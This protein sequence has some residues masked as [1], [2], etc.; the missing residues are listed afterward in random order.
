[1][2]GKEL[3]QEMAKSDLEELKGFFD[4]IPTQKLP[5][6]LQLLKGINYERLSLIPEANEI[7]LHLYEK[8]NNA[9]H[10]WPVIND[11]RVAHGSKLPNGRSK[12]LTNMQGGRIGLGLI[13]NA[14]TI[15][16]IPHHNLGRL[17]SSI[18][19]YRIHMDSFLDI[20][21]QL[22]EGWEPDYVLFFLSE[23]L[24]LPDGLEKS[25]YPVIGLPG[26]PWKCN[27]LFWDM[28]FFDAMMPAMKHMCKP[29]ELLGEIKTLYTSCS[30]IQGYVPWLFTNVPEIQGEKEY[31]VVFTG[32][33][34]NPF[35]KKRRQYIWKLLKLADRY[36]IYTGYTNS[37]IECYE[38]MRN[39]KIVIHCP[40]MQGGVNLRP[41]EAIACGALL[42]HEE[43]D[44]SI[45]EFFV[46]DKEVV[47]FN[48]DNFEQIIEYYLNHVRE[49]DQIVKQAVKKNREY[50]NIVLLMMN[51]IEKIRQSKV[52]V[53]SRPADKLPDDMKLNALG[54]SSFYARD[55]DLAILRFSKAILI[56]ENNTKYSNNLAVCLMVQTFIKNQTNPLIES[57]LL[58]ANQ[59]SSRTIVSLFNLISFYQFIKPDQDKFLE[60]ANTLINYITNNVNKLP[61]FS[62]DELF[63]Y[64]ETSGNY[65]LDSQIFRLEMDAL[66]MSFPERN[67]YYQEWIRKT[68]L[69]RIL[70][71]KGDYYAEGGERERSIKEY[72]SALEYCPHNEFI[73]EKLSK[74]YFEDEQWNNAEFYLRK[75][76]QHSPLHENAHLWLSKIELAKGEKE[77]VKERVSPLLHLGSLKFRKEFQYIVDQVSNNDVPFHDYA[78]FR[79]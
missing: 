18:I 60:L 21:N 75:L 66:M 36:K 45:E 10:Y 48:E 4:S 68:I 12:I 3:L 62:N 71:Y 58:T 35:H 64:V 13:A 44:H 53:T 56:N 16:F 32:S 39:A 37:V 33:F 22:P 5:A 31:D 40:N 14:D 9:V 2:I 26:D 41:F 46:S 72:E 59:P 6:F 47:L 73:L 19:G 69:W 42:L 51:V 70:E 28:K 7:L 65:L 25:P 49:R 30:G 67:D 61:G 38:I 27:K 23:V 50:A 20:L 8:C 11:F 17:S 43:G 29:Y 76:L 34:I 78:E 57:L 63:F 77:K 15:S 79:K 1:M 24:S 74:L 52:T 55:L 54:I